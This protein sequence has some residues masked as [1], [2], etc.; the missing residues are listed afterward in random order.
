MPFS[1]KEIVKNKVNVPF[2]A[3]FVQKMACES[4]ISVGFGEKVKLV[5]RRT[6]SKP[7]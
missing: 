5:S 1:I 7:L 4:R 3:R 2:G 6:P